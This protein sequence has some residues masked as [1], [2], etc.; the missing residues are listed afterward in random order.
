MS[1]KNWLESNEDLKSWV[2]G[3][4]I[5]QLVYHGT[6]K[7]I[8]DNF[9]YQK[10]QRFVLFSAFDVESKGF[11]FSESPHDALEY[12][13]NIAACYVNMKNP[14]IDPRRESHLGIDR[15]SYQK[16]L[17]L[18]KVLGPLI[19]RDEKYGPYFDLGVRRVW[20]QNRNYE[21]AHQWIYEALGNDGIDWDCLDNPEVIK[22]MVSL[23]YDGTFVQE[24]E[25]HLGRSIFVPSSNQIKIVNWVNK[26]QP[27]WQDKDDYFVRKDKSG[28]SQLHSPLFKLSH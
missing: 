3:S 19:Q 28:L 6:N 4:S 17:H 13:K 24:P 21:F 8:F 12:G 14:L 7:P 25:S 22:R 15:L 1:F 9:S 27:H 23:G 11:F 5:Q 2:A 18:L 10:S 16:E 20:V 26:P